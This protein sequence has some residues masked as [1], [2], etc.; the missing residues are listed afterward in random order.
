MN[1]SKLSRLVQ[2][3]QK[4]KIKE[5]MCVDSE[6]Q[7]LNAS[8]KTKKTKQNKTKQNKT[9]THTCSFPLRFEN[10]PCLEALLELETQAT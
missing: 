6:L 5:P 8:K 7:I 2:Q 1:S 3:Q 4:N 9:K 10:A